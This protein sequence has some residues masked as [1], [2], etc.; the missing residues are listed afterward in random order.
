[1]SQ[2]LFY[3]D[4]LFETVRVEG[5]PQRLERHVDRFVHAATA[6][7]YPS[8]EIERG[9]DALRTLRGRDDGL[10][11]V[12]FVRGAD[13]FGDWD[14]SVLFNQ[15][16]LTFRPRPSLGVVEGYLPTDAMSE[17]KTTSYVRPMMARRAA[18]AAGFDDALMVSR[19]GR[20][21][22]AS[23]ANVF[24]VLHD[25]IVT[26]E[27]RGILPGT[28]R[29]AILENARSAGIQIEE[30][31]IFAMELAEAS[32]VILTSAGVL[33]QSALSLQGRALNEHWGPILAEFACA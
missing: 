10:W 18:L 23:M 1:M 27:V 4:C 5:A 20:L 14:S 17:F 21:G 30:R 13:V 6:L 16:P 11:R 25:Q 32:E 7:H 19:C 31:P 26:P 2:S 15:R 12:T 3:G 29:A 33:A 9:V 8:A 28:T 24:L 22:E